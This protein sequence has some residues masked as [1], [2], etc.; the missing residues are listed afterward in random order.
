MGY[1]KTGSISLS[2]SFSGNYEG[3]PTIVYQGTYQ[4]AQAA[5][6]GDT[7]PDGTEP[8]HPIG[9]NCNVPSLQ[10]LYD[11]SGF[12]AWPTFNN[13][14]DWDA[15]DPADPD[16]R[17]LLFDA[18]VK[19]GDTW[20]QIRGWFGVTYP[21]SG[22]LIGGF[23]NRRMYATYE[24]DQPNPATSF[25]AGILNPEPSCTDSAFTVTKVVS[26][27]QTLFYTDGFQIQNSARTTFGARSNYLTPLVTPSVQ[28]GGTSIVLEFNACDGI[29]LNR[30]TIDTSKPFLADATGTPKWTQNQNECDGYK[31]IRWRMSL[32]S[33]LINNQVA[34]VTDVKIPILDDF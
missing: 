33:N 28:A 32:I 29:I 9:F 34:R 5:N 11:Y 18:S 14:F 2:P 4:V 30:F 20:Q 25:T 8:A 7:I 6:V 10:P 27:G 31:C 12:A 22:V 23:P 15:G 24:E 16:D 26:L 17:I 1:Q 21:C 13:Y 19:E 3:S